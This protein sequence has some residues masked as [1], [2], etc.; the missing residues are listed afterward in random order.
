M[1]C[2]HVLKP[3]MYGY[4]HISNMSLAVGVVVLS[5]NYSVMLFQFLLR[6]SEEVLCCYVGEYG[7]LEMKNYFSIYKFVSP[8]F[9][10]TQVQPFINEF[11]SYC[12]SSPFGSSC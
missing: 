12:S 7:K 4:L 6:R 11:H 9:I 5:L 10:F 1:H 2:G 8:G 3:N